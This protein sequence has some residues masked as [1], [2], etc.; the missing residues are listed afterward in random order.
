[1]TG[2]SCMWKL[3][4][5]KGFCACEAGKVG[6][7]IVLWSSEYWCR[8]ASAWASVGIMTLLTGGTWGEAS[9]RRFGG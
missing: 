9:A 7:C 5:E 8:S 1:M 6:G 3:S 2:S 4:M